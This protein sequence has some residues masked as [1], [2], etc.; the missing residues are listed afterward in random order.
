M[1]DRIKSNWIDK[2]RSM[3]YEFDTV[4]LNELFVNV[5]K[6][7]GD[8]KTYIYCGGNVELGKKGFAFKTYGLQRKPTKI[9]IYWQDLLEV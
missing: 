3:V 8:S 2:A 6:Q 4:E 5:Y 7:I 9:Y 1:N